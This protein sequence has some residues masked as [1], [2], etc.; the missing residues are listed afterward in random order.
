MK[1]NW[2]KI[3]IEV[4]KAILAAITGYVGGTALF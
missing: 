2:K 4:I 1:T 3:L